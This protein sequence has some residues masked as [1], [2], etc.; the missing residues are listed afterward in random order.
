MFSTEIG[1]TDNR[2]T[3]ETLTQQRLHQTQIQTL[4]GSMLFSSRFSSE[5]LQTDKSQLAVC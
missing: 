4:T 1:D 2:R 3:S 5:N